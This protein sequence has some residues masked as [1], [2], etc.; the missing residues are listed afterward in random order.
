MKTLPQFMIEAV[1]PLI[2]QCFEFQGTSKFRINLITTSTHGG[3]LHNQGSDE[4]CSDNTVSWADQSAE[5]LTGYIDI[6]IE[7][8]SV[9]NVSPDFTLAWGTSYRQ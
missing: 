9:M 5:I 3:K 2:Y 8:K 1:A 6:R 4:A 7:I